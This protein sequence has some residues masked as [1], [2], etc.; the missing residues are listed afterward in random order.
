MTALP[1][2]DRRPVAVMG[3]G[4]W[5]TLGGGPPFLAGELDIGGHR[6]SVGGVLAD[7][8]RHPS[9]LGEIFVP[10]A[11]AD[12]T[13]GK[14]CATREVI[15]TTAP[16]SAQ[17][18]GAVAAATL[19]PAFP[20]AWTVTV[21]PSPD[22]LAATVRQDLTGLYVALAGMSLVI[23]TLSIGN[24][25]SMSVMERTAEIGTRRAIGFTRAAILALFSLEAAM[26]GLMGGLLGASAGVMV[27]AVVT[28]AR[29]WPFL[30]EPT[31][32]LAAAPVGA[33]VGLL[34]GLVPALRAAW[35]APAT[36]VRA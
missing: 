5:R 21:P 7:V 17:N 12:A 3:V 6:V 16:G 11:F 27:L 8:H 35:L 30:V 20:G 28:W 29:D 32:L 2:M 19:T 14:G 33:A 25:M 15:V 10:Q 24:T 9:A 36:A 4:A 22:A 26:L 18:V 13:W 23:G 1:A 34:G 31:F